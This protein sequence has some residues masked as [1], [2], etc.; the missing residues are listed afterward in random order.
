MK[1][2]EASDLLST[3]NM[4][5]AGLSAGGILYFFPG[6]KIFFWETTD[7]NISEDNLSSD[8]IMNPVIGGILRGVLSNMQK[9]LRNNNGQFM[10]SQQAGSVMMVVLNPAASIVRSINT[11]AG[12]RVLFSGSSEIQTVDQSNLSRPIYMERPTKYLGLQ[13]QI[14][15]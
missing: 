3:R 4:A 5:I 7:K 13:F 15:Y 14:R 10:G 9:N 6:K 8:I 2:T 1:S 11:M 12:R